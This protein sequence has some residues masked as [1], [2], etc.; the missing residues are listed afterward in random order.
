MLFQEKWHSIFVIT[1]DGKHCKNDIVKCK[2]DKEVAEHIQ[3]MV[4][5]VGGDAIEYDVYTYQYMTK[6]GAI[7]DYRRVVRNFFERMSEDDA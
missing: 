4:E 1:R 6:N 3:K 7:Q 5:S 2:C